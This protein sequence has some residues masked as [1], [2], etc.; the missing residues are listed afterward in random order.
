MKLIFV[1]STTYIILILI[2]YLVLGK[3]NDISK[4]LNEFKT[5]NKNKK[6]V[7]WVSFFSFWPFYTLAYFR[8]LFYAILFFLVIFLSL[9]L[10]I[11]MEKKEKKWEVS[12]YSY[13]NLK[14]IKLIKIILISGMINSHNAV[15]SGAYGLFSNNKIKKNYENILSHFAFIKS[16][17]IS[18]NY[19]EFI[20][21]FTKKYRDD[22]IKKKIRLKIIIKFRRILNALI[23]A[24]NINFRTETQESTMRIIISNF[25]ISTN[26]FSHDKIKNAIMKN[27]SNWTIEGEYTDKRLPWMKPHVF[28][29]KDGN[30]GGYTSSY[31]VRSWDDKKYVKTYLCGLQP[32]GEKQ[33]FLSIVRGH[34][35][36]NRFEL[37]NELSYKTAKS[38]NLM[39]RDVYI[40]SELQRS[41]LIS[42]QD[43]EEAILKDYKITKTSK[44][45]PKTLELTQEEIK[46]ITDI[47][48]K[49]LGEIAKETMS[50]EDLFNYQKRFY[51][52]LI[53]PQSKDDYYYD[54]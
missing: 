52:K 24:I 48:P 34:N 46:I 33:Y 13:S 14:A 7:F 54:I 10:R 23:M 50:K 3:E 5:L 8:K 39:Y 17:G 32:N 15:F 11:K 36:Y 38:F 40:G 35:F 51:N 53:K 47:S 26:G 30:M 42:S 12:N 31:R 37:N 22:K 19:L 1:L 21:N 9:F 18:L 45:I 43:I 44:N 28:V 29:M 4:I 20:L 49:E 6:I 27:G 25:K 41:I 2:N 16:T